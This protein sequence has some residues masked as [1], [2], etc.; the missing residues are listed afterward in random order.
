MKQKNGFT[1]VEII[2]IIVIV[3]ILSIIGISTY[4][5]YVKRSIATEGRNLLGDINTGQQS[6]YYRKGKYYSGGSNEQYSAI[7]GVDA[8]NNKYFTSYSPVS[9]KSDS[10]IYRTNTYDGKA[11]TIKGY[12]KK[13][14]EIIDPF[15]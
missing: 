4:N 14:P 10:F 8:R 2:I 13:S 1:L 3:G 9:V 12:V 5:G 15:K 6:Y 7:L 11:L